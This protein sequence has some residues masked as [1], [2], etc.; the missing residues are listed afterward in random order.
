LSVIF[1]TVHS[2]LCNSICEY[3]KTSKHLLE[4]VLDESP[5]LGFRATL[6][7][8]TK[9]QTSGWS[10][11]SGHLQGEPDGA[12][13]WEAGPPALSFQREDKLSAVKPRRQ[14]EFNIE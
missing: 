10:R 2:F 8:D 4:T 14:D 3:F 5:S 9:F 6:Q 12:G 1:L 11:W 7:K 13:L